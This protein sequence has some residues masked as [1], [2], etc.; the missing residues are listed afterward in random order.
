M[1]PM[2]Y[3]FMSFWK[4]HG[5]VHM[6]KKIRSCIEYRMKECKNFKNLKFSRKLP[7]MLIPFIV[8]NNNQYA[9]GKS[10]DNQYTWHAT[11]VKSKRDI[12]EK[13]KT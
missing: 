12:G 8:L 9:H 13:R 3:Y 11:S 10:D 6:F 4:D 2:L 1:Y 5:A 7:P